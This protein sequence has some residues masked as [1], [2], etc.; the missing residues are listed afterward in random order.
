[1][2][3]EA[4]EAYARSH[5]L[6]WVDDDSN[7][8]ERFARNR[9]RLRV[10]PALVDAF[11]DAEAVLAGAATRMA[12]AAAALD[13]IAA[14]DLATIADAR[15]LDLAAWRALPPARRRQALL[16]WLR[17]ALDT[18]APPASL[19]ERLMKEGL[20]DR[21]R[22]WPAPGGEL[23][24]YRGRLQ[25]V[26][27]RSRVRPPASVPVDLS[28][29]GRHRIDAWGGEFAVER[30]EEGGIPVAT[31]SRLE[32]RARAP[33]DAFQAGPRRPPRSLKLQFQERGVA[34]ALREGPIV[35]RRDDGAI[36]FVPGLGIDARAR[37]PSGPAQVEIEWHA[38]RSDSRQGGR[39]GPAR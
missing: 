13:E 37:A 28:R 10:W 29:P 1:M 5:R 21:H 9:L 16:Q 2:P 15:G 32:L 14:A 6:R 4:I 11:A 25:R 26:P 39:G 38:D 17:R 24:S 22:R 20:V 7:D 30:V 35:A 3:R 34:P 36:V 19:V 18:Q 33:R 23:Q 31:A 12:H 8:D 27:P